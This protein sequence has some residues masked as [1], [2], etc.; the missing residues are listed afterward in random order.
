[1]ELCIFVQ[2]IMTISNTKQSEYK[3]EQSTFIGKMEKEYNTTLS[4][5]RSEVRMPDGK[6]I[7]ETVYEGIPNKRLTTVENSEGVLIF[8]SIF[9]LETLEGESIYEIL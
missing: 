5:V 7:T 8:A 2:L 1:M 3:M 6:A 9:D 4:D